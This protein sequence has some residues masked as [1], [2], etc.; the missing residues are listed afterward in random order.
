M[1]KAIT[2][3]P[4]VYVAIKGSLHADDC[5]A[6]GLND[7]EI[8]ALESKFPCPVKINNTGHTFRVNALDAINAMGQLG[9]KL[10]SSTGENEITWTMQR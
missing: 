8:K 1:E 10:V 5:S 3:A 9:Y 7:V 4:P 6:F 2:P